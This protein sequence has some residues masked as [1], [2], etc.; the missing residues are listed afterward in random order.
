MSE[1]IC[2]LDNRPC[3]PDCP[4]RFKDTPDGGCI[5]TKFWELGA[6]LLNLGG[7]NVGMMFLPGGANGS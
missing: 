5:L 4:D 1:I 3:E 2:P 7:G 6:T